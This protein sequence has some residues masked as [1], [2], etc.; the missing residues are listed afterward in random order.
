MLV[1]GT[2]RAPPVAY[3]VCVSHIWFWYTSVCMLSYS[4]PLLRKY[5]CCCLSYRKWEDIYNAAI[6][7]ESHSRYYGLDAAADI[8]KSAASTMA[9]LL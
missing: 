5:F 9:K 3:L 6:A 2:V 4:G 7:L 1:E 8:P